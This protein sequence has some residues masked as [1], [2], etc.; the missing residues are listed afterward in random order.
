MSLFKPK[1]GMFKKF[2]GIN[3]LIHPVNSSKCRELLPEQF[4]MPEIP[5][6][7]AFVADYVDVFP[8]PMTRYKEGAIF[9]K[10]LF[11][12]KEYWY[13]YTM[14][15]TKVVPMWGGRFMGFPKYIADSISINKSNDSWEGTVFHKE[16]IK[17]KLD[18]KKGL[19]KE[20][21]EQER[22]ITQ[23]RSFFIGNGINLYPPSKG[24]KVIFVDLIHQIVPKWNPV[25]GMVR[26]GC[27]SSEKHFGL[28]DHQKAYFGSYNEFEG[29]I[30]LDA[31]RLR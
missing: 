17:L 26:I 3:A 30:N 25:Y 10:C 9:I 5:Q 31:I 29:G 23:Q 20:P 1:N 13:T 7:S 19:T 4:D 16:K 6:A 22:F 28:F 11:E 18:F 27:D 8:W 15:V 24:P 21:G 2:Y 14:P 12:T